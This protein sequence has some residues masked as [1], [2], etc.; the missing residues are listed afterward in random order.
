M[1]APDK[2]D[3]LILE[4]LQNIEEDRQL[5]QRGLA[6]KLG[7]ALGLTNSY[8]K[9]CMRKGLVKIKQAPSNR[10]LY[11]LTPKGFAEKS[12]LT[13]RYLS[14]SLA[15]YRTAGNDYRELLAQYRGENNG[16]ILLLGVSELAEIAFLRAHEAGVEVQGVFDPGS[17][18]HNFMSLPVLRD[19]TCPLEAE[20]AILTAMTDGVELI[21]AFRA[22]RGNVPVLIPR[23]LSH[24]QTSM[25]N[26]RTGS[27]T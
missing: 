22:R 8:L 6:N 4:I 19:E 2:E 18:M 20:A 7:V 15:M 3:T 5:T 13:A 1:N 10:Y 27:I 12:R 26:S 9:R 17:Q 16:G 23:F 14:S 21:N 11:Y 24:V 25:D